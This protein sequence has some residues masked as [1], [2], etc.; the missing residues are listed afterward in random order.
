MELGFIGLGRMGMN[1]V[2]RL[3]AGGH[4][5]FCT[6]RTDGKK[7]EAI[8]AGGIWVDRMKEFTS[9]LK[10][11]RIVWTMVPSGQ[12]TE[13]TVKSLAEILEPG[14]LIVDGGNSDY[15][16]SIRREK[17]IK[18]RDI[19]FVDCGTSGGIWG[20]EKG[21]CLM[22][23]GTQADVAR[24]KPL[25]E[26]LAQPAGWSRVGEAGTGHFVKMVHNAVEYG[27]MQAYAEG[28][29]L[30]EKSGMHV[31]LADVAGLWNHG[32][33]VKSWL[34]ELAESIFQDDKHLNGLA[35]QVQD[36]GECRWAI[37]AALK[38]D[39]PTPVFAS[40]LFARFE[41]REK[42]A[43]SHRFLAALRNKFGGHAVTKR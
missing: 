24:L 6:A 3:T 25:F 34:L 27:M 7:E 9:V 35:G 19:G 22:I 2:K 10:S 33:V 18:A 36:S 29:E 8:T 40:A 14:D 21:Y 28:F 1:M 23:G 17:D 12:A 43:F 13:E 30:L 15:R 38:S 42:N 39:V 37:E 32:S 26:T 41:S 4:K 11:P 16:D 31:N 20:L 5:V